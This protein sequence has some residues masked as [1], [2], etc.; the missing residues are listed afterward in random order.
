MTRIA[1]PPQFDCTAATA[2]ADTLRAAP[3]PFSIDGS[4]VERIGIAGLQ[5][6]LSARVA[7]EASGHPLVID[8]PSDPL[9][10]AARTAGAD[11]L[12]ATTR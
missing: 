9:A 2:L 7:A 3:H 1:L 6:L 12:L 5:L 8:Q 4:A 11:V 10:A